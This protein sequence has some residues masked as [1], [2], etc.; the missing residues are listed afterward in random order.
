MSKP[1][2]W[3]LELDAEQCR[4]ILNFSAEQYGEEVWRHMF[5]PGEVLHPVRNYVVD[6]DFWREMKASFDFLADRYGYYPPI[7]IDHEFEMTLNDL[8]KLEEIDGQA[9][10]EIE[11]WSED[12]DALIQAVVDRTGRISPATQWGFVNALEWRDDGIWCRTIYNKQAALLDALGL[13]NYVSPAF[14]T[15]ATEPKTGRTLRFLLKEFTHCSVPHQRDLKTPINNS[16][17]V[18]G[19]MP[20]NGLPGLVANAFEEREDMFTEEQ[21]EM[22]RAMIADATGGMSDTIAQMSAD[23][24]ELMAPSEPLE[25][26]GDEDEDALAEMSAK[27]EVANAVPDVMADFGVDVEEAREIAHAKVMTP[28][29]Y[30][31]L[32]ERFQATPAPVQNTATPTGPTQLFGEGGNETPPPADEH[33]AEE[34]LRLAVYNAAVEAAS[35]EVPRSEAFQ[36]IVANAAEV[37]SSKDIPFALVERAYRLH[38]EQLY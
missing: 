29:A 30:A 16:A 37:E 26:E 36:F 9:V 35:T 7:V 19:F 1:K 33:T 15:Q 14:F 24:A 28:N 27:L 25:N 6:E 34:K 11:G 12:A 21:L 31:K 8:G 10:A 22:I 20:N 32:V 17:R 4:P 18:L 3:L 23:L 5:A 13:I 2:K 38:S